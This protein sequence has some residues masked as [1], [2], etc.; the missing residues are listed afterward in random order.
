MYGPGQVA[1]E[2]ALDTRVHGI[3]VPDLGGLRPEI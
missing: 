2:L 3:T 1:R